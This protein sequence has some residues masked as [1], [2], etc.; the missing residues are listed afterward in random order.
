LKPET[1]K[2]EKWN[3]ISNIELSILNKV[4]KSFDSIADRDDLDIKY[5]LKTGLNEAFIISQELKED[6][7]KED[8]NSSK[9]IKEFID[10]DDVRKYQIRT[11]IKNLISIP[12]VFTDKQ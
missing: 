9:L 3:L 12:Y 11:K 8:I 2:E 6:I 4:S 5:G 10:G 1:F 7:L